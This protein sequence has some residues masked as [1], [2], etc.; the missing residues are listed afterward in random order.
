MSGSSSSNPADGALNPLRDE[1]LQ[2]AVHTMPRLDANQRRVVSGRLKLLL[3]LL[4]CAAPVIASYF[5]YYVI[6]P[7]GRSNYAELI[8][9]A[10]ELPAALALADLDG[11]PVDARSLRGQWL[12]VAV[13]SGACGAACEK[14]LYTQRQLREM[15]G[16]EKDRIDKLW[17]VTDAAPVSA[18]LR[19]ALEATPATRVLRVPAADL[20]AWLAPAPGESLDAHLYLVDPMGRWMMRAPA[21]LE[22]MKFKRDL[23]RVLRASSSWDTPGR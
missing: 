3:L 11:R 22:P 12:L 13:G 2:F 5:T 18:Q 17:L 7:E 14:R 4:A 8:D 21:A 16:R 10:R 23:E 9:P 19:A 6:R 15:T 20:A 1:P